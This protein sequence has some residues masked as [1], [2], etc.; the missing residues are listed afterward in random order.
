[1]A[2]D[3]GMGR[4]KQNKPRRER[5]TL[6]G[7]GQRR[8]AEIAGMLDLFAG[9]E[10][11]GPELVLEVAAVGF[12]A[13]GHPTGERPAWIRLADGSVKLLP[14]SLRAWARE[15]VDAELERTASGAGTMFPRRV[16]FGVSGGAEFARLL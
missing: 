8:M 11:G 2:Y 12:P 16:A 15:V 4:Q 9:I 3:P 10:D 14:E 6:T 5:P 13:D 1:M 7:S